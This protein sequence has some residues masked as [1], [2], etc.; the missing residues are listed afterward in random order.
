MPLNVVFFGTPD[1]AAHA[2]K[3]IIQSKHKI[4][5]VVTAADKPSGRGR[6]ITQSAVKQ[7][8]LELDL[9]VLQPLNLKKE[10]F[11]EQL[12]ALNADVFVVVAFRMLPKVV[13]NMPPKGTFNLHASLLPQYRGAAPINWAIINGEQQTGVTTF[14]IDE[15]IDTGSIIDQSITTIE[16][17]MTAGQLH[18]KLMHLGGALILKTLDQIDQSSIVLKTQKQAQNLNQAPKLFR[19][20]CKIDFSKPLEELYNFIRGLSPYPAAHCSFNDKL[21]KFFKVERI[22]KPHTRPIASI[23]T[24]HKSYLHI[25]VKQGVLVIH[26][27]QMQGKKR[28]QIQDFL[29]GYRF[30]ENCIFN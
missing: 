23:Q 9:P 3:E 25:Y 6:K 2:L 26:E 12:K 14:M 16:S 10:A 7:T 19:E 27:L 30:D 15:K 1:F 28:M 11:T 29:R 13:F 5:G 24:D 22:S 8:A 18:D 4:L 21:F 20:T 17:D